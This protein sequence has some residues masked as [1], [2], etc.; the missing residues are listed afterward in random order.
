M[1]DPC[2]EDRRTAAGLTTTLSSYVI[3][4][5]LA[6]LGAQAVLTTFVIDRREHLASF[7]AV[8]GTGTALLITSIIF[9]GLGIDEIISGG[10]AGDWKIRTRG[11][12]FNIQSWMAL[13]GTILV[14]ASAFLGDPKP[15]RSDSANSSRK[16][17]SAISASP[18]SG[19]QAR[20]RSKIEAT[21]RINRQ[22]C[23]RSGIARKA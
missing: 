1:N 12:K 7:Y 22:R 11:G 18:V 20:D 8:G 13:I 9:G 5:T 2:A 23:L 3:T 16:L 17:V 19:A 10:F 6:V 21:S 4:A 14:V 15:P